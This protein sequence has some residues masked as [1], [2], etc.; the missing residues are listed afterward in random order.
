MGNFTLFPED[1]PFA[2][3][4]GLSREELRQRL[5][6]LQGILAHAPVPIA[7]AHDA[8][9][10]VISANHALSR[11]LGLPPEA[12]IS[13]TPA[14]GDWPLYRIQ[15][16]GVDIPPDEL[17]M[18]YAIAHRTRVSNEIELVR[19]DGKVIY[20]QNDVEPL[21]DTHGVIY[22]CVSVCVDLTDRRLAESALRDAD[23]RKDEFLA[24]LSHEL[25]NPLAPIRTALEVMRIGRDNWELVEKARATMERQLAHLVRITDDLLD[26]SRITQNKVELRRERI[27]LRSALHSAI[28]ST[29]P[30]IDAQGQTLAL[31]LPRVPIWVNADFTRLSQ[32]FANLLNNSTKYTERGGQIT[33]QLTA[34]ELQSTVIVSDTGV[35]VPPSMLARIFDMFTQ[36][37][38]FRDRTQGGL[39]IG[40]TLAKRLVEL[41]GGTIDA[42]SEGAD[43]GTTFTVRLPL[44]ALLERAATE[45][46][47]EASG[48]S[49]CRVLIAEDNPDAAEMMRVMLSFKGHDVR[50]ASNGLQA[51]AIAE[52][53]D[54]HIGFLD[55]GMPGVDGYEAA[56]RIRDL[57][58]SRIVLVALTGWGQDE[59][60][61]RSKEA[62]FDH[63]LTKPPEPE[64]L[65]QLIAECTRPADQT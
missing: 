30:L 15:R 52:Q 25:R 53:F 44:S 45:R 20:V 26:V 35:G 24:T 7:I 37:Q 38:E 59:D 17:P 41:H 55:I 9:C 12:N 13:L 1:G 54:P 16:N 50:V 22:G 2:S 14:P 33:V 10:Q 31:D 42:A 51:V 40:L 32:V 49:E 23:R 11:L 57:L 19:G 56:R 8:E 3:H 18:Q 28:E 61:R 64:V 27:D 46:A 58:G 21:F 34:D 65:D 47:A 60:K 36:V 62:G 39:G 4:E 29:R 43:R 63:H 5:Q 48:S 6:S